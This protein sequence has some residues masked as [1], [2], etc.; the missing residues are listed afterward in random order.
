MYYFYPT[1]LREKLSHRAEWGAQ[2]R[3]GPFW[4]IT[5]TRLQMSKPNLERLS[6]A[7]SVPRGS[8][9]RARLQTQ[10]ELPLGSLHDYWL[11]VPR[12]QV[13]PVFSV[14]FSRLWGRWKT[15]ASKKQ[16]TFGDNKNENVSEILRKYQASGIRDM[17][18][19]LGNLKQNCC[20]FEPSYAS[21]WSPD[22]KN[23]L[24]N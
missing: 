6:H 22:S 4:M 3:A 11:V 9:G 2:W 18:P 19:A 5:A 23:K 14:Q 12:L 8:T 1:S 16:R 13:V 24:I 21:E 17:I 7:P 20:K 10:G 15:T